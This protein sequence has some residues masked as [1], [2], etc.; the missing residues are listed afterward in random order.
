MIT[1]FLILLLCVWMI[2]S[3][4]LFFLGVAKVILPGL[5]V[6]TG[7]LLIIGIIKM[8]YWIIFK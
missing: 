6:A 7:V 4:V 5:V 2:A 8:L 3:L 1:V